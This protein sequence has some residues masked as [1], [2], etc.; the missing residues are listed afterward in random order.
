M[1]QHLIQY[2]LPI[3]YFYIEKCIY[4]KTFS[5]HLVFC[6]HDKPGTYWNQSC[7]IPKKQNAHKICFVFFSYICTRWLVYYFGE[8]HINISIYFIHMGRSG[9]ECANPDLAIFK[10]FT[11]NSVLGNS[12]YFELSF[13]QIGQMSTLKI[14]LIYFFFIFLFKT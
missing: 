14:F 2:I 7:V 5:S 12:L 1:P 3:L 8:I 6:V 9:Q 10:F 11:T 4:N 13:V